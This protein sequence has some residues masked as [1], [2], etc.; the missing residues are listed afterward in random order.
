[1]A[2]VS[3][4]LG[5]I[6]RTNSAANR[7][8]NRPRPHDRSGR[9]ARCP[10]Q[11]RSGAVGQPA[12]IETVTIGIAGSTLPVTR[13]HVLISRTAG[14]LSFERIVWMELGGRHGLG[15]SRPQDPRCDFL[16][17]TA[18]MPRLAPLASVAEVGG[19]LPERDSRSGVFPADEGSAADRRGDGRR[20]EASLTCLKRGPQR[21]GGP[22][23]HAAS[24]VRELLGWICWG[25]ALNRRAPE[26]PLP[27]LIERFLLVTTCVGRAGCSIV[28][29]LAYVGVILH[30]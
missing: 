26:R 8:G 3:P 25:R 30:P 11:L 5:R 17:G 7:P 9:G 15:L 13:S 4:G 16:S 18:S 23:A 6:P 28:G 27:P 22:P 14:P 21:P 29:E 19:R 2:M 12:H 20:V 10:W 24:R 1:M